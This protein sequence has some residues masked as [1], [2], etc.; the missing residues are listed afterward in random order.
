MSGTDGKGENRRTA[1]RAAIR[2]L[3]VVETVSVWVDCPPSF[4][5]KAAWVLTTLLATRGVRTEVVFGNDAD[6]ARGC[7]LAYAAAPVP[8]VPTVPRSAAAVELFEKRR[9]L[10]AGSYSWFASPGGAG[11]TGGQD[12]DDRVPGAFPVA[13][14]GFAVPFDLVASAFVLLAAW[15][16]R[17]TTERDN[18]GR[19]PYAASTFA[20]EPA[21]ELTSPLAER[22]S[23][24][25]AAITASRLAD[26][27]RPPIGRLDWGEGERFAL[28]LTHDVDGLKRWTARGWLAAGKRTV[29]GLR[30]RDLDKTLFEA[31]GMLHGLTRDLPRG[32]DPF[33]TFPQLLAREDRLGLSSTFFVLPGHSHRIDGSQPAVYMRRQPELL[34]LL[35]RHGREVGLH[36]NHRDG[37]DQAALAQDRAV[38]AERAEATLAGIRYHYLKCLYHETLPMLDRAGFAYDTSVAFAE[39]EGWRCGTSSPFHPYDLDRDRPLEL[40]E[41]PLAL[42]D[43]TLQEK[44]YR[45][46]DAARALEVALGLA[47]RLAASG[48]GSAVLWHH[49]RFHSHV[50][51]GYGDVYWRLLEWA[52][53]HEGLLLPAGELVWRW[54]TLTGDGAP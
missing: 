50:G 14:D 46:L 24:L 18:H 37:R 32:E 43:S 22:Y 47:E 33:W 49:N 2:A 30:K 34:R 9:P 11:D 29:G 28:A 5:H 41:L 7:A 1:A 16:E 21:L 39:H 6:G 12:V 3:P 19:L 8:G 42:M 45:A 48:G 26:L 17:T 51:R 35:R 54:R 52:A 27:G 53:S 10:P 38:L 36:G 40:I 15:D 25:L 4:A 44:K 20:H 31:K 23:G 13:G